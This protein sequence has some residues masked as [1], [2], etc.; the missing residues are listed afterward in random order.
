M[1]AR[2]RSGISSTMKR[3]YC[4]LR[5]VTLDDY[6]AA[7]I[8]TLVVIVGVVLVMIAVMIIGELYGTST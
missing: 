8:A 7:V 3:G 2:K 5:Q 4:L 1:F 6:M